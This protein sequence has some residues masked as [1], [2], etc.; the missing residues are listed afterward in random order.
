VIVTDVAMPGTSGLDALR[1]LK[2]DGLAS[3]VVF[4]TM[5][6]DA[7]LAAEALRAGAFGFVVKHAAGKELIAAIRT[8]LLGRKYVSPGLAQEVLD[9]LA[10]PHPATRRLTPRQRDVVRL[11]AEGRTMKEIAAALEMSP[12]TAETHK[13]H[14]LEA[15]G[16]KTT[17]D[18]IRCRRARPGHASRSALADSEVLRTPP[19]GLLR[20]VLAAAPA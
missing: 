5:H 3:K 6:A 20:I 15:L 8:V 10:E 11:L 2:A 7:E 1:S 4:L 19:Y 13:Y 12:R 17:A 16:L 18:L 14:A 9:M